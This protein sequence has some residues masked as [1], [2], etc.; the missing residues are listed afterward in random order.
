MFVWLRYIMK[1]LLYFLVIAGLMFS[2]EKGISEIEEPAANVITP[3]GKY[4][5][6][7]SN[8]ENRYGPVDTHRD[9]TYTAE[10]TFEMEDDSIFRLSILPDEELR[11]WSQSE[12]ELLFGG[13]YYEL[14]YDLRS[15]SIHGHHS[16]IFHLSSS[17]TRFKGVKIQ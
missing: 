9:T 13:M 6:K 5:L 12:T 11:L 14:R 7:V 17:N 4:T 16:Y 8:S 2:C 10:A 1:S 3:T 15:D